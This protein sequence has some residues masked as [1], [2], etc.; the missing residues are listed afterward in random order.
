MILCGSK[1]LR[2]D[3]LLNSLY[4]GEES[5]DKHFGFIASMLIDFKTRFSNPD[6]QGT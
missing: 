4:H 5:F 2:W 1:S 3:D 6:C